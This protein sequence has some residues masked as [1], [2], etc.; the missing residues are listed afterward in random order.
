MGA[1]CEEM[2]DEIAVFQLVRLPRGHSDD[3]L[4]TALLSPVAGDVRSFD[5]P[6]MGQCHDSPLIGDEVFNGHL[7]FVGDDLGHAR[8][9]VLVLKIPKLLLDDRK[10]SGLLGENVQQVLDPFD[11]LVVLGRDLVDFETGELVQTK[12]QNGVH[13]TLGQRIATR[14]VQSL[15]AANQDAPT[16]HLSAGPFEGHQLDT[17]LIAGLGTADD[18][19]ELI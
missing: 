9:S 13:L 18:A 19:N 12:L 3:P 11:Q 7:P 4:A 10:H 5:E 8:R 6:I 14:R 15:F 17:S 2:L 16:L 1:A